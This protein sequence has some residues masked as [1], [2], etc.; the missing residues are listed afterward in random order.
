[1][2]VR[3]QKSGVYGINSNIFDFEVYARVCCYEGSIS[4]CWSSLNSVYIT[5]CCISYKRFHFSKFV[6]SSGLRETGVVVVVVKK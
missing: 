4:I 5:G 6:W 2:V 3:A 1:M